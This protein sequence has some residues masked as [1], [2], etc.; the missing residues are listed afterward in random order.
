[1]IR[2]WNGI[3]NALRPCLVLAIAV[4]LWP[5]FSF[6]ATAEPW[7]RQAVFYEVFVRSFHDSD[8]DGIGDIPG[9]IE[10]LDDL[11]DANPST[12]EDLGV[13]ALWLMPISPATSYHGYDVTDYYAVDPAYGTLDDLRRLLVETHARGMRVIL[14]L[15]LNHTSRDHPWF[16]ASRGPS[17]TY[18]DWYIWSSSIPSYAGPWGQR[19][20]HFG[21]AGYYYGLFWD[22]MPDLNYRNPDVTEQMYDVARFWLEEVGVDGFRLDAVRHLIEDGE[23]QENTPETH[24]WLKGFREAAKGWNEET[25]LIG[26]VWDTPQAILPYLDDQMDLCFE[27]SLAGA[28]LSAVQTGR[29]SVLRE[30]LSEVLA[31]YPHG[32]YAPFLSNH[33]QDRAMSQLGEDTDKAKLAASILLTLPGTPF[34]YYGEEIGMTGVKPDERIRTPM[35]WTDGLHAGFTTGTPWQPLSTGRSGISVASQREDPASLLSTYRTLI[36]LRHATPALGTGDLVLVDAGHPFLLSY[37]RRYGD[38]VLWVLHNLSAF[39]ARP[40]ALLV[41]G[42]PWICKQRVTATELL[43]RVPPFGFDLTETGSIDGSMPAIG[44]HQTLILSLDSYP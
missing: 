6:P 37:L 14:D 36:H 41:E 4:G 44:P 40:S 43:G 20:W 13:T 2:R 9:L 7:W 39:G 16:R 35:Q 3:S 17:S 10:K 30:A 42:E 34:L 33:D 19:V 23:R 32:Q 5:A 38:S 24:L 11:N 1:V 8:G 22:G 26:E 18:R 15:V 21:G 12:T 28:I 25:L 29:P 27:F 31:I